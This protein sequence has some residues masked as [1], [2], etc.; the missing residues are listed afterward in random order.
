MNPVQFLNWMLQ[1]QGRQNQNN[2][3]ANWNQMMQMMNNQ[4]WQ[5]A[6]ANW[7]HAGAAAPGIIAGQQ[8][9]NMG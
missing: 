2:Q 7:Q 6:L 8:W 5:R 3:M 9:I 4:N 1:N